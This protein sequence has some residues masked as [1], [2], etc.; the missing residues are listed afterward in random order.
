MT[1]REF[2]SSAELA[3][4]FAT[5]VAAK[6]H[7][8][9]QTGGQAVLAVSGGSTPKR[10][11]QALSQKLV[12]WERVSI[13]PVDERFVPE[14]HE[15]SNARLIREHLMIDRAARANLVSLTADAETAE[16]A[17]G[18]VEERV[19]ALPR[20][21]DVAVLGMGGDGHT[22]SLFPGGDNLERAGSLDAD[23]LVMAMDAPEQPEQRLTM[24][25]PLLLDAKNLYLHIEGREKLDVLERAHGEGDWRE[26]PIRTV[27][28]NAGDLQVMWAP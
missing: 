26:L 18:L 25:L 2:A 27:L 19:A 17:A 14:T 21:F 12:P 7:E 13:V 10:F 20:P 11:F 28:R 15:R 23:A 22:A 4:A 1:L 5:E 24:T 3:E 6:L 9:M 16:A 8:A